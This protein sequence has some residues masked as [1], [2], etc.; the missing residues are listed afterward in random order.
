[1]SYF[2]LF[3]TENVEY[4]H[5]SERFLKPSTILLKIVLENNNGITQEHIHRDL[6]IYK[7]K[8]SLKV[9]FRTQYYCF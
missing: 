2:G 7:T 5:F 6:Y 4:R 1:M 3:H 8:V 9:T